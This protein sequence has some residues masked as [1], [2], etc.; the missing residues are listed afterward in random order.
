MFLAL[1]AVNFGMIELPLNNK[2]YL[3]NFEGSVFSPNG[4]FYEDLYEKYNLL[5]KDHFLNKDHPIYYIH[6]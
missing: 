6:V 2:I 4:H 1:Y 5:N 3:W